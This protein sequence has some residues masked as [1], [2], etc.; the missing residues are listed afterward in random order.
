[1]YHFLAYSSLGVPNGD[2]FYFLATRAFGDFFPL[3]N[4]R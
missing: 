1:M 4:R 2:A 3:F